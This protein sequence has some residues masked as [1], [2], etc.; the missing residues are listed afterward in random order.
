LTLANNGHVVNTGVVGSFAWAGLAPGTA[1]SWTVAACNTF[2]CGGTAAASGTTQKPPRVVTGWKGELHPDQVNY[3]GFYRVNWSISGFDP[4]EPITDFNFFLNGGFQVNMYG[5]PYN[6]RLSADG[7]G[8][9][10]VTSG[11]P[12]C[13][14]LYQWVGPATVT[15]RING[16]TS[17]GF[18]WN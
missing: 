16:V 12:S 6:C 4:G 1:Y 11:N 7:N 5:S 13:R 18:A 9:A 17:A 3:P 2:S 15:V 8:N 10:S 14:A